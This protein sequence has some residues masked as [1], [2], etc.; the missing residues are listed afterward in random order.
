MALMSPALRRDLICTKLEG[1]ALHI[2]RSFQI[3]IDPCA[4]GVKLSTDTPA[5]CYAFQLRADVMHSGEETVCF[6]SHYPFYPQFS[7]R[8]FNSFL[9]TRVFGILEGW[10]LA[11]VAAAA[12]ALPA[13]SANAGYG[14]RTFQQTLWCVFCLDGTLSSVF[15][16]SP[17]PPPSLLSLLTLS[18]LS[19]R[20]SGHSPCNQARS[21]PASSN[22]S[23]SRI[24]WLLNC[25]YPSLGL[26]L[27]ILSAWCLW[28]P[29]AASLKTNRRGTIGLGWTLNDD[30]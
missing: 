6:V 20:S 25:N 23:P 16:S 13:A 22:R 27:F 26:H 12:A 24:L 29:A 30:K 10:W 11:A 5:V 4:F 9:G 14:P 7:L 17:P 3:P 1:N 21:K 8:D 15:R 2:S 28:K 19:R 18:R